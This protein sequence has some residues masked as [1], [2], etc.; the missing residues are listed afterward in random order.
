M[1]SVEQINK[2]RELAKVVKEEAMAGETDNNFLI[3]H[4][5]AAVEELAAALTSA[6]DAEW[7]LERSA[8]NSGGGRLSDEERV[9]H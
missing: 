2:A 9:E 4:L 1:F 7:S 5:A 3:W 8:K 6:E